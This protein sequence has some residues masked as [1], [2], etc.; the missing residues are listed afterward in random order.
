MT[1]RN[2]ETTMDHDDGL[3][4][5]RKAAI[6]Y[7]LEQFQRMQHEREDAVRERN[8]LRLQL[9]SAESTIEGLRGR[10]NEIESYNQ[11]LRIERD[12]AVGHRLKWEALF[13]TIQAQLRAFEVPHEPLVV[14]HRAPE[15]EHEDALTA[16]ARLAAASERRQ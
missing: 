9:S 14:E 2:G 10:V 4:S 12:A 7:G 6:A 13:V 3:P 16:L 1:Y 8:E 15:P 11:S 5:D